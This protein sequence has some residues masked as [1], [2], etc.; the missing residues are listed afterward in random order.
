LSASDAETLKQRIATTI[1]EGQQMIS[2]Y[3]QRGE[4]RGI[5]IG[6]LAGRRETLQQLLRARFP[7]VS[8]TVLS[9]VEQLGEADLSA[10]T[11]RVLTANS[12]SEVIGASTA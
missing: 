3:E 6:I 8:S 11:L 2:I 9:R 12:P 10:A 4:Q 5:E 1:P 7:D